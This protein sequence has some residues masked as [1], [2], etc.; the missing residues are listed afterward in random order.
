MLFAR[1]LSLY[2]CQVWPHYLCTVRIRLA[3]CSRRHARRRALQFRLAPFLV[4][5][6]HGLA[7]R[8]GRFLE[9]LAVIDEL[10]DVEFRR[11]AFALWFVDCHHLP[12]FFG[13]FAFF[14]PLPFGLP[15]SL[16]HSLN[17][18]LECFLARALPPIAPVFRKYSIASSGMRILRT[19][20]DYNLGLRFPQE[21]STSGS[22][23]AQG[24]GLGLWSASDY[25][26]RLQPPMC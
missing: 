13:A 1:W 2:A 10:A 26:S 17:C 8:A 9:S 21:E 18:F 5:L 22:R 19:W 16:A 24:V 6:R 7:G 11:L 14:F 23:R 25:R 15:P 3:F 20:C 12:P 4:F